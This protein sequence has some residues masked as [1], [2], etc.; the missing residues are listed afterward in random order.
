MDLFKEARL[1]MATRTA[2][3]F[4]CPKCGSGRTRP[5]SIAI[6]G[7]TRRRKTVGIS[8]RSWWGSTNTY[9]SDLIAGL[10]ERPS[11]AGA[12]LCMFLGGCALLLGLLMGSAD[13]DLLAFAVVIGAIGLLLVS[14]GIRTRRT[15]EQLADDQASWD[16]SWMCARCGHQWETTA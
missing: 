16:R 8:R 5:L 14:V 4:K 12:Y 6:A 2:D 9:K 13:K 7:G 10:P 11:N 15:T 3:K 1:L